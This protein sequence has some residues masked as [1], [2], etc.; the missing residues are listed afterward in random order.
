MLHQE[1]KILPPQKEKVFI[2]K[3]NN[4]SNPSGYSISAK[5]IE[6][7]M[8]DKMFIGFSIFNETRFKNESIKYPN[9]WIQIDLLNENLETEKEAFQTVKEMGA[10]INKKLIDLKK[11]NFKVILKQQDESIDEAIVFVV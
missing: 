8:Q 2:S 7:K 3:I 5:K 10:I 9:L 4:E 1:I 11:F 6:I